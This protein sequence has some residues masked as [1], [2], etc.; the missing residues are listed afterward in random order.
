MNLD[1]AFFESHGYTN[2]RQINGKWYG[3]MRMIFTTG[4]F[5]DLNERG[6]SGGRM[7][8]ENHYDAV[9]FFES[10]DGETAPTKAD[11]LTADK[12]THVIMEEMR[13]CNI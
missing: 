11:G 9:R 4:I 1:K 7:C 6:N 5:C 3:L 13:K 2:V 8:F 10:W 12:R